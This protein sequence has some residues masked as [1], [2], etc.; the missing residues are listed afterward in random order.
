MKD[1][2]F[3]VIR[4]I[5]KTMQNNIQDKYILCDQITELYND[6]IIT[7]HNIAN[8]GVLNMDINQLT[9]LLKYLKL[10]KE[11]GIIIDTIYYDTNNRQIIYIYDQI[12]KMLLAYSKNRVCVPKQRNGCL[13][14]VVKDSNY[15]KFLEG[16]IEMH[17][18]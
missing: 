12:Y 11:A 5:L 15:I 1:Y 4:I 7:V 2:R 18:I 6:W 10:I 13:H 3:Y 17:H 8:V 9:I 14:C 16:K